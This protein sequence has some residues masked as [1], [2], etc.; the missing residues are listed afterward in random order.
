MDR[1]QFLRASAG[2]AASLS[3][4]AACA[5]RLRP[6]EGP[7]PFRHGVASGDPLADRVI[8]WTRVTV[9]DAPAPVEVRW[10]V[11]R[12]P[13]LRDVVASGRARASAAR[14]YTVK[15]DASGLEPGEA[16][17]YGF[18]AA[19]HHSPVGRTRTLPASSPERL[20][21]AFCSCSCLP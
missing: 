5:D 4:L 21:L 19:G 8:L 14:D 11:A 1:R 13:D 16:W 6:A 17:Y 20:K 3:W 15:V 18:E 10:R 7:S 9:S 2:A 12:D